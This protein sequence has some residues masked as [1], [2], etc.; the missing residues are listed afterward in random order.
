MLDVGFKTIHILSFLLVMGEDFSIESSVTM[1]F[2]S[3]G[4]IINGD[5]VCITVSI[6]EDDVYEENQDFAVRITVNAQP[7]AAVVGTPDSIT[8][9]I[10]DN[11]GGFVSS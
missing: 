8:K 2:S 1:V 10:Q 6:L 7:S 11:E 5:S 4:G 3:S 9:T